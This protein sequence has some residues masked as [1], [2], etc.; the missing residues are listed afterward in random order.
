[1]QLFHG[2]K[3]DVGLLQPLIHKSNRFFHRDPTT[4]QA[5]ICDDAEE[6]GY[7]LP[8]DTYSCLHSKTL[9]THRIDTLA[10]YAGGDHVGGRGMR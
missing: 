10:L 4:T 9:S 1:M 2:K 3:T 8:R 7:G 5:G 6:S